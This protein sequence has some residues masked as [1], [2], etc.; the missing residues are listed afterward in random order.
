MRKIV[1]TEYVTLDGTFGDPGGQS[2]E[3]YTGWSMPFW[4]EDVGKYKFDEILEHDALLLGRI[5]YEGF[6][7]AWPT[8]EGTGGFGE[9]MNGMPKYVV[10]NTLQKADWNNTKIISGEIAE[11]IRKLKEQPGKNI[12]V[13]GSGQ[14]LKFL[15]EN[16]LADEIRMLLH[17]VVLGGGK[18]LFAKAVAQ[19]FQLDNVK[20][21]KTGISLLTYT[22]NKK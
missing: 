10:S 15:L 9:K 4:S 21:F 18:K 1:A 11:Q 19:K 2:K 20:T 14:L 7:A 12:L 8:M 13:A 3:E 17:P 22:V 6:A 16:D 5:T